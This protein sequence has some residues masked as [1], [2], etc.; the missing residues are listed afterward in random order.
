MRLRHIEV[1]HAVYTSGS[2]TQA[3]KLLCVSQPS[4]S[5]VLAH[6][7]SQLGF[8]LFQRG[9][10][11]ILP[12]E[13][14]ERLFQHVAPLF[15][16]IGV[17]RRAADNLKNLED[18]KIRLASTPAMGISLLPELA[19]SFMRTHPNVFFELETLHYTE[20]TIALLE[21]RIDVALVFDPPD[22]LGIKASPIASGEFV[23]I[24][25]KKLNTAPAPIALSSIKEL[26]FIRLNNRGPLG[27]LLDAYLADSEH[28]MN[29]VAI[30]ETYHI[31][32]AMVA[33]G[34]GVSIVD[35]I[36]A[37]ALHSPNVDVLPLA[38]PSLQFNISA[39]E[40]DK[41]YNAKVRSTFIEHARLIIQSLLKTP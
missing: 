24:K 6:A 30:T 10:G 1:F 5:K 34:V 28:S 20:I 21:G 18:R 32:H 25:P 16:Q 39:L 13:E 27:Q 29:V 15:D 33:R 7:E 41:S 12:T 31:A 40:F 35:A 8:K 2:V 38:P 11:R 19:A 14:A 17:V 23:F 9:A 4:V 26:P 36:T 22:Q 37:R 3:A